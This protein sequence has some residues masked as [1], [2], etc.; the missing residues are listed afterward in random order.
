MTVARKLAL[1]PIVALAGILVLAV[2]L[3][4]DIGKVYRAA[5]Y[6]NENTVPSLFVLQK[7]DA[8]FIG[9]RLNVWQHVA[10]PDAA[11]M[12]AAEKQMDGRRAQ[13]GEALKAYEALI[14]DD[15]DRALLAA[16]RD[17][18][19]YYDTVR[20][21]VLA[22]SRAGRKAEANAALMAVKADVSKAGDALTQHLLY[23]AELGKASSAAAA[24]MQASA[25]WMGI[26]CAVAVAGVVAALGF[27][28]FRQ[29]TGQLGGEPAD[30]AAVANQIAKGDFSSRIDLRPGDTT[31][32]FA[33]VSRMQQDLKLH[34]EAEKA[35]AAEEHA[36]I[37]ANLAAAIENAR[38]RTAL[39]RVSAGVT[40]VDTGGKIIY[41]N[42]FAAA[43][44]RARAADLRRQIPQFDP[45][46]MVGANFEVT[47]RLI[48]TPVF[49]GGG[50][51]GTVVQW[52]DRTDEI[53][54]EHEIAA[55][56][57]KALE[58]DLAA[59]IDPAGKQGFFKTL[60]E[61][62]NSLI[63]SVAGMIRTMSQAATEVRT[64]AEEISRGNMDLSQRTEE[65]ASSLEQTAASM[66]EM[67]SMVKSNADN[68]A[69]ANQLAAAARQQAER[70]G[71]VV[72]TAV[73]AMNE[74]NVAS[75]RIADI[76][77]VIDDIAFQTNL[78]ALNAAVEA[79]RAGDQGRGFAV[80]PKC[81]IS[82]R[83]VRAPPRRSR[84]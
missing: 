5:N 83:A 72:G 17:A 67:T 51:V 62:M 16:D 73:T 60:A 76:I 55:I 23:N 48:S 8:N 30:V 56:V 10:S 27:V 25:I 50:R 42:D 3:I 12:A 37:E 65:Q 4:H 45:E 14:A 38:I 34:T 71:K 53:I 40:L 36:R 47:L 35:R 46:R 59:R 63:E 80:L 32:L 77:G 11:G 64:G 22:L 15:K 28:I 39:D 24:K 21:Q 68:A 18:V 41:V 82:H 78:L 31:S 74:I 69:Q 81:A 29:L 2:A 57:A 7:L 13:V 84:A 66:E 61:G 43:M 6:A 54:A 44:F 1:L 26:L 79:A 19:L 49:D 20:D 9:E 33:A 70:G 58:G 52:I 75:N